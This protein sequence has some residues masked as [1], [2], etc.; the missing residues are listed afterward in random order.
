MTEDKIDFDSLYQE[1]KQNYK[2]DTTLDKYRY[3]PKWFYI[4]V[5]ALY[6]ISSQVLGVI[7]FSTL[8]GIGGVSQYSSDEKILEEVF[9]NNNYLGVIE[10]SKDFDQYLIRFNRDENNSQKNNNDLYHI[11]LDATLEPTNNKN[12]LKYHLVFKKYSPLSSYLITDP[13]EFNPT[14]ITIDNIKLNQLFKKTA[15]FKSKYKVI[16]NIENDDTISYFSNLAQDLINTNKRNGLLD[17]SSNIKYDQ[18][19]VNGMVYILMLI[20]FVPLMYKEFI[21]DGKKFLKNPLNFCYNIIGGVIILFLVAYFTDFITK[22]MQLI[23]QE[24]VN[25]SVNQAQI[26]L[27]L[28][29]NSAPFMYI[30]AILCA[31]IIEELVFRKAF[32]EVGKSKKM[33]LYTQALVFGLIHVLGEI[34]NPVAMLINLVIYFLAGLALG[35]IYLLNKKNIYVSIGVHMIWNTLS[36]II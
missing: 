9:L 13:N 19:L 28:R 16:T 8:Q 26:E 20:L 25:G 32:F 17:K 3:R 15:N 21:Y 7:I 1:E 22:F 2:K 27:M 11:Y 33:V 36:F 10:P 18:G 4:L 30:S 14:K 34:K 31:P 12:F 5:I 29:A 24:E 35:G 23:F 6:F